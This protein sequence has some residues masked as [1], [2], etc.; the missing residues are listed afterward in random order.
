MCHQEATRRFVP[1]RTEFISD[2]FCNRWRSAEPC[3][4]PYLPRCNGSVN[5]AGR[6]SGIRPHPRLT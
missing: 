2:L 3:I 1:Q 5:T 6:A 4:A